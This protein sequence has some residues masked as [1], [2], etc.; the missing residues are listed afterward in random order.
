MTVLTPLICINNEELTPDPLGGLYWARERTL[1]VSDL[2]FEKGSSFAARGAFL[3]PYDT[4]TTLMRLAALMRRYNPAR[5]IS[6]GDAFHDGEAEARMDD[7]DADTLEK[8]MGETGWLWVLGNHDPE[9]PAR[10][11]ARC[12]EEWSCGAL[13]FRHEP[14]ASE[15]AGEIAGHLHPCARVVSEGRSL[16]RRCFAVGPDRLVMPAM[17]A[18]AGGLNVLDEA[19]QLHFSSLTAWVMGAEGVY[20]IGS[21]KLAPD[22][23]GHAR[24][25][26]G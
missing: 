24:V 21:D 2:H 1:I 20:P 18:Y 13:L 26:A 22:F 8:L 15:A 23:Q 14:A 16:R 9:P 3:P 25:K 12:E 5:V 19:F 11:A 4:R 10:F 6:L 17:G 7:A